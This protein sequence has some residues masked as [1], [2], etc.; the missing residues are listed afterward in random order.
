MNITTTRGVTSGG[1]Y[2]CDY[3]GQWVY[4]NSF[5][6]CQKPQQQFINY[7]FPLVTLDQETRELLKRIADALEKIAGAS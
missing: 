2:T 1:G 3:C 4:W 7:G 6:N 5:H